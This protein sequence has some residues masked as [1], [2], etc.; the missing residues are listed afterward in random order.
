V[1]RVAKLASRNQHKLRELR[2]A[3]P[4]WQLDLLDA[5]EYPPEEGPGYVDNARGK[6]RFARTLAPEDAWVLGED[7]GIEVNGL[8]G[9]PGP[10]SARF[11][12]AD[13]VGRLLEVLS[14]LEG[15]DR[16]ARYVCELVAL[17][18]SGDELRG[19][20]VLEGRISGDARGSEGF[21]YDPIFVPEGEERTVAELGN[22]WK[23]EHSH[24]ARAARSLGSAFA[25]P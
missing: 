22:T 25:R 24:R 13:P 8:D 7:S 18:P 6:A 9:R 12:G 15:E 4:D 14:G 5:A 11:G 3:L 1:E 21:G 16:R 20:G 2:A 17:G 23:R 10:E 19:T